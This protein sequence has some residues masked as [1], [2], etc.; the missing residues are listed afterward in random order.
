M[1]VNITY[2]ANVPTNPYPIHSLCI[3]ERVERIKSEVRILDD[4]IDGLE[5]RVSIVARNTD[6][7]TSDLLELKRD[8][9]RATLLTF[10]VSA[11]VSFPISIVTLWATLPTF[12]GVSFAAYINLATSQI[13]SIPCILP[14]LSDVG[15]DNI[16]ATL[17][18]MDDT[19]TYKQGLELHKLVTWLQEKHPRSGSKFVYKKADSNGEVE[20]MSTYVDVMEKNEMEPCAKFLVDKYKELV[21]LEKMASFNNRLKTLVLWALALQP[22][23]IS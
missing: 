2:T 9:I 21:S 20:C 10:G 1:S 11:A 6:A 18:G 4:R 3:T 5:Q 15:K 17:R 8:T 22:T 19:L 16:I 7:L 23:I 13:V 14:V 12:S